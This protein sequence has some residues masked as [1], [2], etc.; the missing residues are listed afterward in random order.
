MAYTNTATFTATTTVTATEARVR[1]VLRQVRVDL[2]AATSRGIAMPKSFEALLDDLAYMLQKN[3]IFHFELRLTPGAA[4]RY[5]VSDDGTV[6]DTGQHG[7]GINF[8]DYQASAQ[9]SLVIVR[10]PGLPRTVTDEINH[11]GWTKPVDSLEGEGVQERAYEKD[12]YGV[13][14]HRF[15]LP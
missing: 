14:R 8:Y 5:V 2:M 11:R 10:R 4:W 7:G 12:G 13:V 1:W 9:L 3:A 6:V 15:D